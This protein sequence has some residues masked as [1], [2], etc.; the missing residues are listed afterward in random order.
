MAE[1]LSKEVR[2]A[3]RDTLQKVIDDLLFYSD[4]IE[5]G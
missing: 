5:M 2:V 3:V 1:P 4:E